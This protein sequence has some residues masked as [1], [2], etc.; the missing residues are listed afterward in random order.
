MSAQ[1]QSAAHA[2][3]PARL[4]LTLSITTRYGLPPSLFPHSLLTPACPEPRRELRRVRSPLRDRNASLVFPTTSS[5]FCENTGMPSRAFFLATRHSPLVY[6]EPRRATIFFRIRTYRRTPRFT[7]FWPKLPVRK[8]SRINTY[9]KS[10]CN[11]FRSNTYK[12]QGGGGV[13]VLASLPSSIDRQLLRRSFHQR[14]RF[15]PTLFRFDASPTHAII[16]PIHGEPLYLSG[17]VP[18]PSVIFRG[19][20]CPPNCVIFSLCP[21]TSSSN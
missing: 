17:F 4:V 11:P 10:R 15:V 21:T 18:N 12:K 6:P 20:S 5:L 2:S 3:S 16:L 14:F 13:I 8:L 1:T 7:V 19:D 9:K